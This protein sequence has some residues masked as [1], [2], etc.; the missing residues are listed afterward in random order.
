MQNRDL[1]DGVL[2]DLH[3]QRLQEQCTV[4]CVD[5]CTTKRN[6]SS[7]CVS[8][9]P[10]S[11]SPLNSCSRGFPVRMCKSI[12]SS[13][14]SRCAPAHD[15][16]RTSYHCF[17]AFASKRDRSEPGCGVLDKRASSPHS[18]DLNSCTSRS[19]C[20]DVDCCLW[21]QLRSGLTRVARFSFVC[22]LLPFLP[23]RISLAMSDV[24]RFSVD[25][26]RFKSSSK[27]GGRVLDP[28]ISV[29]PRL[30]SGSSRSAENALDRAASD[31]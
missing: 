8:P 5:G 12:A 15:R 24:A 18:E 30:T 27:Q 17:L 26:W 10:A 23:G 3:R 28:S 25:P 4:T 1:V 16:S 2:G 29:I 20:G 13:N 19:K 14:P 6:L 21:R 11:S 22:C 7:N 9:M 31:S